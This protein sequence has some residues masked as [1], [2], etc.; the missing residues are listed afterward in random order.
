MPPPTEKE[1]MLAGDLYSGNDP[2]LI[3]ERLHAEALLL[4]FNISSPADRATR[5]V[6]LGELLG[7]LGD[8][9]TIQPSLRCDYG[10]N[11]SIGRNTFV[12]CDC[13][14]LDCNRI[15]IGE[16]VQ[17]APRVQLYTAGHPLDAVIRRSGLEFALPI[18]IADNVWLGGGVIVCP[19]IT[20]GENSVV[21]AGSVV[22]RDL[23]PNVLAVG[24]PA[25]IIRQL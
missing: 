8:N 13:I 20:I 19:G 17:I 16:D 23:P 18:T 1:K 14:F 12:N 7:H 2:A 10:T 3:A 15:T 6:L 22:T 24:N 9:V 25:R 4:R 11:L 5:I 21:G